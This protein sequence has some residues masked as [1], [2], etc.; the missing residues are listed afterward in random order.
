MIIIKINKNRI[1]YLEKLSLDNWAQFEDLEIDFPTPEPSSSLTPIIYF[2]GRNGSG[3][4]RLFQ[5]IRSIFF[6]ENDSSLGENFNIFD[7]ISI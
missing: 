3:K 2:I 5:A 7:L 6:G 1:I 4:T